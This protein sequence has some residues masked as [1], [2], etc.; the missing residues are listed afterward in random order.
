MQY[1]L[2]CAEFHLEASNAGAWLPWAA[3]SSG[4]AAWLWMLGCLALCGLAAA[5]WSWWRPRASTPPWRW[6]WALDAGLVL[7]LLVA[8]LV[9]VQALQQASNPEALPYGADFR[10]YLGY[11]LSFLEPSLSEP[12]HFRYPLFAWLSAWWCRLGDLAPA[13]GAMRLS[14]LSSALLPAALYLLGRQ[15]APRAVAAVAGFWVLQLPPMMQTLGTPSDYVFCALI[16]VLLLASGVWALLRGGWWRFALF[17]TTCGAMMV[18]TAKAFTLLLPALGMVV[19]YAG[20][21]LL[22]RQRWGWLVPV[23]WL[24]PVA[25]V[26]VAVAQHDLQAFS[27]EFQTWNVRGEDLR[28]LTGRQLSVPE[29]LGWGPRGHA[30]DMGYWRVGDTRA[31][32]N[33]HRVVGFFAQPPADRPPRAAIADSNRRGLAEVT[34]SQRPWFL[35][36]MIPGCLGVVAL[37]WTRGQDPPRPVGRQ[38]WISWGL[39]AAFLAGLLASQWWGV[40]SL[41]YRFRYLQSLAVLMPLLVF[42]GV[43]TLAGLARRPGAPR[44]EWAWLPV[45]VLAVVLLA[46]GG[47]LGFDQAADNGRKDQLEMQPL[48]DLLA[49]VPELG[50]DDGI[51]DVSWRHLAWYLLWRQDVPLQG[52]GTLDHAS[53]QVVVNAPGVTWKR[54]F[55]VEECRGGPE[56]RAPEWPYH[57]VDRAVE[58]QPER[59]E[60]ISPCVV[61]DLQPGEPLRLGISE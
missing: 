34:G 5:A 28:Q 58:A 37:R 39:A 27:F 44:N 20:I 61:E 33:L 45:P 23:A 56:G 24:A 47:P 53:G 36:L 31:L 10:D 2:D 29:G 17:G 6:G 38:R 14:L 26:W 40:L 3:G 21:S 43:A 18:A 50:P 30:R 35:W 4:E 11:V 55:L 48:T 22:R 49:L 15:I 42:A 13:F 59:F 16:Q 32:R 8:G 46:G 25:L 7:V 52:V 54:R 51:A 41:L 9:H 19:V 60:R 57:R 1:H 12:D